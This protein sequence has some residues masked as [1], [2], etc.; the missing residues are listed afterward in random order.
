MHTLQALPGEKTVFID[1]EA[2]EFSSRRLFFGSH[3]YKP[4]D[5]TPRFSGT[6]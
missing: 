4:A 2:E 3:P 1:V 6:I 5:A